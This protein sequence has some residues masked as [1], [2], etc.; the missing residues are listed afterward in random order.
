M[1]AVS[2]AEANLYGSVGS[3]TYGA[4]GARRRGVT[5]LVCAARLCWPSVFGSGAYGCR[6]RAVSQPLAQPFRTQNPHLHSL[7]CAD[8]EAYTFS[9]LL[10]TG[11][12]MRAASASPY[13]ASA[14][15]YAAARAKL[16]G[17]KE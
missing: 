9:S 13:G 1:W 3:S 8:P 10:G 12:S 6:N 16:V 5:Q 2:E 17:H 4:M 11:R 14:A 15:A 7:L